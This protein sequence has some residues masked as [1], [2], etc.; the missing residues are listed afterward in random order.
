[1]ADDDDR[2]DDDESNMETPRIAPVADVP[3]WRK[4]HWL[5]SVEN[6]VIEAE[7]R[8]RSRFRHVR[9]LGRWFVYES[10][11]WS[12]DERDRLTA[13]LGAMCREIG[14]AMKRTARMRLEDGKVVQ[15]I[16]R[17]LRAELSATS[18][19]WDANPFLIN[20][21]W[22]IGIGKVVEIMPQR[23]EDYCTKQTAVAP[24]RIA[25]P[26]WDD[27]VAFVT[28]GDLELSAYLQRAAGYSASGATKEQCIFVLYGTG[29]NGKSVF[30]NTI[31][32]VLGSYAA[33]TPVETITARAHERHPEELAR[34]RGVRLV[35]TAESESGH[36]FNESRIK[37]LTGG[38]KIVARFMRENSFEFVPQFKL[39]LATNNKPQLRNVDPAITRRLHLV[40]FLQTVAKED[41]ILDLESRLKSEWPG[42]LQWVL[43]GFALWRSSGLRPP[44][45][46]VSATEEYVASEDLLAMWIEEELDLI[47]TAETRSSELFASWKKW[48][49]ARGEYVGTNRRLA[50]RLVSK[51]FVK[52]HG[53]RGE[54][55]RG[56]AI[57]AY[58][59][60]AGPD[61][62]V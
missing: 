18:E 30:L 8:L 13:E 38:E 25:T 19:Q 32:G 15:T 11:V 14:G 43:D 27:F 9:V 16:E 28:G 1:M 23:A 47:P 10:G 55:F 29:A 24:E 52:H 5:P 33:T 20:T 59:E 7:R 60:D 56:L 42:I 36:A 44:A 54:M 6:L 45:A 3:E 61:R 49:E 51:R 58:R 2:H 39:W 4:P 50:E 21:V 57:R 31:S 37:L 17:R 41:R 22:K 26:L 53:R 46:V 40:P 35:S 12:W 34:L 62:F 48:A